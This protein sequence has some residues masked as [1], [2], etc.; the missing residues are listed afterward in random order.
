MC[1][2]DSQLL[3]KLKQSDS[4]AFNTLFENYQPTLFR[5]IYYKTNNYDLS[6]DI[7]QETFLKVWLNRQSLRADTIFLPYLMK[8]SKNLLKDHYKHL[9][10]REKHKDVIKTIHA[11]PAQN[12]EHRIDEKILA[13]QI[14]LIAK[15]NL[16]ESCFN[17]FFL[18]RIENKSNAE[19]AEELNISKKKVENQLYIALKTISRRINHLL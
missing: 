15:N 7:V 17:I 3:E 16:S 5:F 19:I 2:S 13:E 8:I 10:V 9:D 6:T 11:S 14:H 1:L 18:S 12:P 4:K